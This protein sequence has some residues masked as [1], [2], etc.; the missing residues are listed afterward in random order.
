MDAA[1]AARWLW[2]TPGPPASLV[3]VA[4][5]PAA[6]LFRIGVGMRNAAYDSGLLQ[7]R[8]LPAPS[9]GVGSLAVGG[10]GK[11]P[12]AGWVADELAR[13]GARPAVVL[14]G[15]GDDETAVHRERAGPIVEAGVERLAAASRA[16]GKGATAL[17]LDDCLQRRDV[18][19]DVMLAVVSAETWGGPRLL[20]PSGPW[21]E[22]LAA[23]RRADAVVVTRKVAVA[24]EAERL[25]AKLAP[26]TRQ[27]LGAVAQ[28]LPS[29]LRSLQG[30]AL[31]PLEVLRGREVLAVCGIGEPESFAAQL[32][33][34][35]ATVELVAFGD[36]H[37]YRE[38]DV[39]AIVESAGP[40][41]VVTTAKDAVKLADRWPAR[42]PECLVLV[43]AV[44]VTA[45]AAA[46]GN[47]LD[48]VATAARTNHHEAAAAS[49]ARSS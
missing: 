7:A 49:P 6:G 16:V 33:A 13:R 18:A 31:R 35:G 5:L 19:V 20:L 27:G 36:H 3:R 22:G 10:A 37:A 26:R 14:R 24:G 8:R 45:G 2:R 38:P 42:G 25:A 21:R 41:P 15:Y 44:E 17:V 23:L 30:G 9:V 39:A 40:R 29:G 1:L 11:T 48:R 34:A 43:L 12:V 47:L 46:L 28:L 4:L 32:A